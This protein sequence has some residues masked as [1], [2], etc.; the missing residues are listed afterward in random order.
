[1]SASAARG[2]VLLSEELVDLVC[3]F[4]IICEAQ[5]AITTLCSLALTARQF[6]ESARRALL[7]DPSYLL[8]ADRTFEHAHML[9]SN[10]MKRPASGRH[11]KR[12]EQLDR[13]FCTF[14]HGSVPALAV[15]NWVIVLLRYCPDVVGISIWPDL[16]VGWP[17]EL[18]RLPLLRDLVIAPRVGEPD[19]WQQDLTA[20]PDFLEALPWARLSSVWL[21]DYGGQASGAQSDAPVRVR[22]PAINLWLVACH[23][24]SWPA[25]GLVVDDVRSLSLHKV[26]QAGLGNDLVL[27]R[28]LEAF[29]LATA[30]CSELEGVEGAFPE[31]H[32]AVDEWTFL[33]SRPAR[34]EQLSRVDISGVQVDSWAFSSLCAAAPNFEFIDMYG[35]CWCREWGND[36]DVAITVAIAPLVH[37]RF[38][39]L[40][41]VHFGASLRAAHALSEWFTVQLL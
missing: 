12:L 15:V 26:P 39:H 9:L 21:Y 4:V 38:V 40:G 16:E 24:S 14:A 20:Y 32:W 18:E 7:H 17:A 30:A 6:L 19:L 23:V 36:V 13:L 34:F 11:V 31:P 25:I 28:R 29:S 22:I 8:T 2:L 27:P 1:M 10:I 35:S 5:D 33:F 3:S 41:E 37:L